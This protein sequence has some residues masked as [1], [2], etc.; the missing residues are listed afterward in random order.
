MVDDGLASGARS[1]VRSRAFLLYF[2]RPIGQRDYILGKLMIPGIFVSMVTLLPAMALYLFGIMLSPDMSVVL[3]TWDIAV[4]LALASVTLIL[5][6]A[7]LAL[8]LSSVTQET[9]FAT[10]AWFAVWALGHGA[11]LAIVITQ[12]VSMQTAP[13]DPEVLNSPIVQNWSLLSLYNN[14][15]HVQN[16]IFGFDTFENVSVSLAILVGITV[17][18]IFVMYRRVSAPI[19]V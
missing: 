19:R 12:A 14:L 3:E 7:S 9:R 17:V 5:P 11:W 10:F 6:T 18:S 4:R 2:S 15:G 13:F 1:D 8:M 16:W